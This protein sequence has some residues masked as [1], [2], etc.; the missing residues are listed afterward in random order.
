MEDTW[1]AR[2]PRSF[3]LMLKQLHRDKIAFIN[4]SDTLSDKISVDNGVVDNVCPF[5]QWL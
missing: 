3:I 4:V 2:L 1:K 5:S